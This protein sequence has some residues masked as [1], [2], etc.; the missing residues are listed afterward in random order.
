[1][2]G[3]DSVPNVDAAEIIAYGYN[4]FGKRETTFGQ[5]SVESSTDKVDNFF[6]PADGSNVLIRFDGNQ[7]PE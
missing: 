2:P 6:D 3:W 5:F 4:M 7:F 1:M